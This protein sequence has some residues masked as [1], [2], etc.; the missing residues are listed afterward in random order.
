MALV[1]TLR[2]RPAPLLAS[3]PWRLRFTRILQLIRPITP[4]LLFRLAGEELILKLA[5]LTAKLCVFLLQGCDAPHG[6]RMPAL[7]ITCLLPQFEILPPQ[8]AHLT[9]QLG[10]FVTKSL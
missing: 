8:T 3:W 7:P 9:P 2:P 5:V 10:H 6:V 1:P 4:G